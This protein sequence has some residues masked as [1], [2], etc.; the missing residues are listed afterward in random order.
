MPRKI[1]N[2]LETGTA[3]AASKPARK[4]REVKP[5]IVETCIS[6]FDGNNPRK[7]REWRP[8][9]SGAEYRD[10]ASATAFLKTCPPGV[11]RIIQVRKIYNAKTVQA[12]ELEAM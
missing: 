11:Y 5:L 4:A 2:V 3:N 7:P 9:S 6:D 12:V 10:E 8:N 1:A